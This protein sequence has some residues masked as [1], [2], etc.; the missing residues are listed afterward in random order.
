MTARLKNISCGAIAAT[1]TLAAFSAFAQAPYPNRNITLVLPFAAGS[2]T[3]TTTR[4]ISPVYGTTYYFGPQTFSGAIT[5]Q[6]PLAPA[7][8]LSTIPV[9]VLQAQS[10]LVR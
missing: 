8:C 10:T 3:D 9:P 4:I 1:L 7:A 5:P 2:G 6:D